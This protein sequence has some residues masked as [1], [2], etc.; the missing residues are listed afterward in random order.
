MNRTVDGKNDFLTAKNTTDGSNRKKIP[1]QKYRNGIF[2]LDEYS[3][4]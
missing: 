3:Y 2:A 4:Y 1:F